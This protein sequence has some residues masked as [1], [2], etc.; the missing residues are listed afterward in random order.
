MPEKMRESAWNTADEK[1]YLSKIGQHAP[2][3]YQKH[4]RKDMIEGY[5]ESFVHRA[6]WG[7][8]NTDII[9]KLLNT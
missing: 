1:K 8:I 2:F 5:I 9:R 4:L 3:L 7:D 6:N